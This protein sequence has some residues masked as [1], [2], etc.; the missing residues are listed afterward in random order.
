[1]S[2]R[3]ARVLRDHHESDSPG[4]LRRHLIAVTQRLLAAHG[5]AGL[6][7]REI[8][9]EAQVA[10]GLL[11]NHFASKDDLVVTALSERATELV[12]EF[13]AARPEPGTATVEEN[14]ARLARAVFEFNARMVP[15]ITGL[16]GQADLLHVFFVGFHADQVGPQA[17]FA[18]TVEYIAAE[19]RLG[20]AADDVDPVAIVEM[21]LGACLLRA[22]AAQMQ[23]T[24]EG[25]SEVDLDAIVN[26]LLRV[27][28][29]PTTSVS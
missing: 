2:P 26:V 21:L 7:T 15:L 25:G 5:S 4:A 19:Q 27:L 23:R 18:A 17:A 10:D 24:A 6:T 12:H 9:R 8:A 14:L 3:R 13:L 16:F 29:R 22:L 1:M 20:R 28:H 11:Y